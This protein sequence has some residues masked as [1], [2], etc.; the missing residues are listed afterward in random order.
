MGAEFCIFLLRKPRQTSCELKVSNGYLFQIHPL[1]FYIGPYGS[2]DLIEISDFRELIFPVGARL[3]IDVV[4]LAIPK[5][6]ILAEVF[7]DLG[8][9]H[10]I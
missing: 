5:S 1:T 9:P 4:V 3:S 8:V 10:V 2:L 7:V 6:R